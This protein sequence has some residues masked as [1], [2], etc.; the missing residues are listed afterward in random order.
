MRAI[1]LPE[2]KGRSLCKSDY[3]FETSSG[4]ELD[5]RK[6]TEPFIIQQVQLES[7]ESE[8]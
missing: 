5:L 6:E 8:S 3:S 2:R 4:S 1:V 7:Y